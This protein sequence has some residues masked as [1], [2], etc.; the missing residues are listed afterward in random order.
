M[1]KNQKIAIGFEII[2]SLALIALLVGSWISSYN[3]I[4]WN[5]FGVVCPLA[6]VVVVG[7]AAFYVIEHTM[8]PKKQT[9]IQ[10]SRQQPTSQDVHPQKEETVSQATTTPPIISRQL[11]GLITEFQSGNARQRRAAS[12]KLGKSQDPAVVS[13][14]IDAFNDSDSI[15]RNNVVDGLRKIGSKEALAFLE[16]HT[17][18]V[19]SSYQYDQLEY[20]EVPIQGSSVHIIHPACG[21][22][23][24]VAVQEF[25]SILTTAHTTMGQAADASIKYSGQSVHYLSRSRLI[26]TEVVLVLIAVGVS[27]R[28]GSFFGGLVAIILVLGLLEG[29]LRTLFSKRVPIWLL[30]CPDCGTI[31][32]VAT[33]GKM[34]AVGSM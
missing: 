2:I 13:V 12:Y 25:K 20:Q 34:F 23:H 18:I 7:W 31:I 30:R 28:V 8:A 15:V 33:N 32:P 27:I 9:E 3:E 10:V 26:A 19:Q 29:P 6:L 24:D 17:V 4:G 5:L 16:S 22:V 11:Q 21:K 14:L 1:N